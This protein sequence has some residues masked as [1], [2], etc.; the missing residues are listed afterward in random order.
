M[1]TQHAVEKLADAIKLTTVT[2]EN[3]TVL[4]GE[5]VTLKRRDAI[6]LMQLLTKEDKASPDLSSLPPQLNAGDHPH[7]V[8]NAIGVDSI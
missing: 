8:A 1:I 5:F 2:W 7:Q 6:A 3:G 4:Q